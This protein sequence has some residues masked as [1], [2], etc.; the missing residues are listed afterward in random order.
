MAL[1]YIELEKA[2]NEAMDKISKLETDLYFCHRNNRI[3]D[4]VQKGK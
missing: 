4:E 3:E 2:Y 1:S